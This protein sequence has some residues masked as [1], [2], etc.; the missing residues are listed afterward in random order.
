MNCNNT[1]K[2]SCDFNVKI[3][4]V[5]DA[6]RLNINGSNRS[7]LNWSEISIPEILCI[8]EVKPDIEAIDQVYANIFLDNVKLIETPFAYKRYTLY[9]FYTAANG[10]LTTLT[11]LVTALTGTVNAII[12]PSLD[13]TLLTALNTL[14]TALTPLSAVPGVPALITVVNGL[15]T[16]TNTLINNLNNAT[17]AV[18]NAATGLLNAIGATPFSPEA[19]C[20]AIQELLEA[21]NALNT[22][23]NSIPGILTNMVTTLNAAATTIGNALVTTAVGIATTAINTLINTTLPTLITSVGTAITNI[24][25]LLEPIDC[26]NS[27]AFVLIPN[28]EGTCLSG[29]KLIVIGVLKQ[30]IVYTAE[31]ATQ[32]VHSA[33][34]EIPFTSHIIPYANF[35]NAQYQE[36]ISVYDPETDSEIFI[37]GYL[38]NGYGYPIVELDEEFSIDCC[39]EDI[40]VYALD[41]RTIFKNVTLFLKA[42]PKITCS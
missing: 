20:A 30:K 36:N 3:V 1:L 4:G 38:Q 7:N 40:Y 41:N 21:L 33:H 27:S 25:I 11:P 2:C 6:S 35:E 9:S 22:L 10:L 42:T 18:S 39:I 31:V 14:E 13:T 12:T 16:T 34:Y 15:E 26:L 8:P 24:L 32:S 28:A 37:N 19:I 17:T 23:V 29:R 5:C